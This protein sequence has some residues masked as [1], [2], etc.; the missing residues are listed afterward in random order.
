MYKKISLILGKYLTK[1]TRVVIAISGGVDSIVLLDISKEYFKDIYVVNINHGMRKES[2]QDKGLVESYC[3]KNNLKFFYEEIL[4]D[5]EKKTEENMRNK[6]YEILKKIKEENNC[7][8]ILTAH[9]L[10]DKIETFLFRMIRGSGLYGLLSPK[11]LDGDRLKP[12]LS[13]KKKEIVE[14]AKE[15]NLEW[16][17]DISNLDESFDR[18]KI[19][20]SIIPMMEEIHESFLDNSFSLI[21]DLEQWDD[22][23]KKYIEEWIDKNP[24]PFSCDEFLKLPPIVQ[25]ELLLMIVRKEGESM[26]RGHLEEILKIIRRG[27]GKKEVQLKNGIVIKVENKKVYIA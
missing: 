18:N 1:D 26:T 21:S 11:V 25:T 24:I 8:Y 4:W 27:V 22:F 6:R 2:V 3:I 23:H 5:N 15:K 20:N 10:N 14:Y 7:K 17:E 13:I 19:R 12:L 9:H 16:N